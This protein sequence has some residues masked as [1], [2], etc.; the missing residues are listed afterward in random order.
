MDRADATEG[1]NVKL[2]IKLI[3]IWILV[4]IYDLVDDELDRS[5]KTSFAAFKAR[6][7]IMVQRGA[8]AG[9]IGSRH[10]RVRL[11]CPPR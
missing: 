5:N 2:S 8:R 7:R 10:P 11:N 9:Q 4:L 3:P 6:V 1:S